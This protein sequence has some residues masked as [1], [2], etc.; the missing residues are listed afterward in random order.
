MKAHMKN[1]T[2]LEEV[3]FIDQAEREMDIYLNDSVLVCNFYL[4]VCLVYF[5]SRK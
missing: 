2:E 4:L 3:E 1:E 5:S